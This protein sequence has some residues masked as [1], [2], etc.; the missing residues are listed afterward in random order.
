[1]SPTTT[2]PRP[3]PLSWVNVVCCVP[4]DLSNE[5]MSLRALFSQTTGPAQTLAADRAAA[6]TTTARRRCVDCIAC[7]FCVK[8]NDLPRGAFAKGSDSPNP[9]PRASLV[10]PAARG[11]RIR[12]ARE[13]FLLKSSSCT[14]DRGGH[15]GICKGF[16]HLRA[17]CVA[18]NIR[19]GL[20]LQGSA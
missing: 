20:L 8:L 12:C 19:P 13:K 2:M 5:A 16:R 11:D 18:P 10:T 7:P 1:M 15:G 4:V 6:A 14:H 9:T 3:L 17:P